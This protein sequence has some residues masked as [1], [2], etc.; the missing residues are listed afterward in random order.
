MIMMRWAGKIDSSTNHAI[1][2]AVE[3]IKTEKDVDWCVIERVS[4]CTCRF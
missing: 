4:S 3:R 1:L 2:V